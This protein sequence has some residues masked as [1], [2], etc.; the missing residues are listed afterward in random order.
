MRT[1]KSTS[2]KFDQ[3]D[4]LTRSKRSQQCFAIMV[5]LIDVNYR[6]IMLPVFVNQVTELLVY[7]RD[8][9]ISIITRVRAKASKSL[10]AFKRSFIFVC[11]N[12]D[13]HMSHIGR[14]I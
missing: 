1:C 12:I 13:P 6:L 3:Y 5:D 11:F 8:E 9:T 10:S 7:A 4:T 14:L 2:R